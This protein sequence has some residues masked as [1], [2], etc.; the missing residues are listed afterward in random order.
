MHTSQTAHLLAKLHYKCVCF[1]PYDG[2]WLLSNLEILSKIYKSVS[3]PKPIDTQWPLGQN[4]SRCPSLC[5]HCVTVA[6]ALSCLKEK[7]VAAFP[8]LIKL[9]ASISKKKE[10]N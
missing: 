5:W 7:G 9:K 2:F 6:E 3:T 4:V 1:D 8:L 10:Y